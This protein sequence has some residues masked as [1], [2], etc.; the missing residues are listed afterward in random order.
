M[1]YGIDTRCQHLADDNKD[2]IY[3]AISY[4][5]YQSATFARDRV[6]G[7]SGYDYSRLQ[8]PTREHLEKI[9][10][11][12]EEGIDALAF[13]TGMAAITAL[14]EIFK[15]GDHIIIDEDLYGGSV[16]LFHSIN[17]KNGLTFTSVDLSSVDVE[18]YIQDNTKAIYAETP[19]NPM[20]RVS[21]LEELSK[22]AKKHE[23]LL[24]VDNTFLS[25]YLQNPIAQGADL[26]VHSGTKFLG[27]HNDTLAGFLCTPIKA[28]AEQIRYLFKTIG[29]GL[30]PFDSFLVLRGI[31]T[32]SVRVERQQENAMKIASWL[33]EQKKV[34][35]VYYVGLPEHPGYEI[36]Q[37]QSR[38]AGSMISFR[39]DTEETARKVLER[40]KLI[41]YAESLGGVES[42]ITYPMLQTHGDVPVEIRERLGITE[43]FLRLSV[44]IENV[45]DLIADLEQAFVS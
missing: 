16:R 31:K 7:G 1:K 4:P 26:V 14:M 29:S 34:T 43:T 22:K 39:T 35:D 12:L 45:D 13:S 27:G 33:K 21:D 15:P 19:T 9:V 2:E 41:S 38:G 20:M 37:K 18:D 42:L 36:N 6:G 5:I 17:V 11:S 30:S 24:I 3:G 28:L 32:L 10:A 25:P 44:G 40:V 8:N 23:L